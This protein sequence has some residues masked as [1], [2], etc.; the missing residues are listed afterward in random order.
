MNGADHKKGP[1]ER[2]LEHVMNT[3]ENAFGVD[4]ERPT[5]MNMP[6]AVAA[7]ATISSVG[8]AIGL[9]FPLLSFLLEQRGF[10]STIIGANTAMAGIASILAVPFVNPIANRIGVVNTLV[11]SALLAAISLLGF[12]YF[13][14]LTAWFALRVTFHGA[15]TA[16]FILSEFWINTSAPN[17]RRGLVLGIYATVL[18][19]GFATGPATLAFIGSKGIMPFAIGA[20]LIILSTIPAILARRHQP[21]MDEKPQSRSVLRYIWLV[22]F[23]T[24]A[25]FTFGAVEQAGLALFPVYGGRTG[26]GETEVSLLLVVLALGNVVMQIPLGMASDR[27]KDR[28]W[29]LLFCAAI[30]TGGVA[31]LPYATHHPQLLTAGIFV[32]GGVTAGMYTVGLAHLG[33]RLSG[34][35]LAQANA[36]F[37]LCYAVGMVIGPQLAGVVMDIFNPHGFAYALTGMFGIYLIMGLSRV[38]GTRLKDS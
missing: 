4:V 6:A 18:S 22:P 34:S 7:I 35:D 23:A 37:I 1:I 8:I 36:A 30:G 31:I 16:S 21:K 32:W 15:I 17:H 9:S 20:T 19:I 33:A 10:S 2:E 3:A 38:V 27:M 5:T 25:A 29:L 11:A 13:P 12:F 28:R 26:F 14:S 24:L